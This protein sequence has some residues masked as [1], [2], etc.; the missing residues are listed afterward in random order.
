MIEDIIESKAEPDSPSKRIQSTS[1]NPQTEV[2]LIRRG[3]IRST[4]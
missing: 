1:D 4:K 2:A 3:I